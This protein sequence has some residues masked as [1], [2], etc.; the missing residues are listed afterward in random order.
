METAGMGKLMGMLLEKEVTWDMIHYDVQLIGG[1]VLH[2]EK[3]QDTKPVKEKHWF[4]TGTT[5]T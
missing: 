3:F 5:P 4:A 1:I 2:R